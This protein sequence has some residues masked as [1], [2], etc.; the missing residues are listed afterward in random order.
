MNFVDFIMKLST[1][2]VGKEGRGEVM[3][4]VMS[5]GVGEGDNVSYTW[6]DKLTPD[7]RLNSR[8]AVYQVLLHALC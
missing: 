1:T 2:G 8:T 7:C 6:L 3:L 4:T 5:S